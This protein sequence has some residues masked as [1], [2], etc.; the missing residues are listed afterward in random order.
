MADILTGREMADH[1]IYRIYSMTKPIVSAVAVMLMEEGKLRLGTPVAAILPEFSAMEVLEENGTRRKAATVMT[2]DHLLTHRS[3]LSYGFLDDC[4]VGQIYAAEAGRLWEGAELGPVISR[5]AELPLAFDPGAE[6]RYSIATDVVGRILEVVEGK[7]LGQILGERVFEP[8]GLTDTGY[9]VPES[10]R[11][12][13]MAM[14]GEANIDE[15][16]AARSGAQQLTPVED[17]PGYPMDDP[18][19]ARGGHGLFSTLQD[20]VRIARFLADGKAD[21]GT[22]L[23]SRKG[24][25]ALWANRIPDGL[26]PMRLGPISLAGY[27]YGLGG[28]VMIKPGEFAGF[29]TVGECGWAG[30]ASTYFWIDPAEDLIGVVMTQYLGSTIPLGDDMRNAVYQAL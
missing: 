5:Y 2:L 19:F 11:G 23:V 9:V 10:E 30:A 15:T 29:S 25:E 16:L 21:D 18:A 22:A 14:F 17:I 7:P 26:Y 1:P 24:I 4:P 12:R 3:G 13:V 27:G 20:Y 8:L 6:W 28:R